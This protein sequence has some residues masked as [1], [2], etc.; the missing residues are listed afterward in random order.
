MT[1]VSIILKNVND[2]IFFSKSFWI[3]KKPVQKSSLNLK[4]SHYNQV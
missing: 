1:F 3:N 2:Q 4:K